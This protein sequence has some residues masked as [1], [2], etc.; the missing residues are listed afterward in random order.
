MKQRQAKDKCLY[1]CVYVEVFGMR[2]CRVCE[3]AA[4]REPRDA[5]ETPEAATDPVERPEAKEN[6]TRALR[7]KSGGFDPGDPADLPVHDDPNSVETV[8]REVVKVGAGGKRMRILQEIRRDGDGYW[9]CERFDTTFGWKH[10]STSAAL[11]M[12]FLQ[13]LVTRPSKRKNAANNPEY[14]Y[15]LPDWLRAAWNGR[16]D[17]LPRAISTRMQR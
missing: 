4:P 3:H 5:P 16:R 1:G 7:S 14:E 12:L 9:T 6:T 15:G 13:G 11:R 17:D 2:Y 10:Q 8:S